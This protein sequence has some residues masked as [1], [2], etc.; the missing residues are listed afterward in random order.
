MFAA[1]VAASSK[2]VLKLYLSLAETAYD[3]LSEGSSGEPRA[4]GLNEAWEYQSAYWKTYL[5]IGTTQTLT[6]MSLF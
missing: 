3:S 6:C 1:L 4:L 5:P 2:D